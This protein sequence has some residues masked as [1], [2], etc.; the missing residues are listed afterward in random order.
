MID[1]RPE[2]DRILIAKIWARRQHRARWREL[3]SDEEAAAVT[4]LRG[5]AVGRADLLA[6]VAGVLEGASEGEFGELL[7][8]QAA[9]LRR[10]AGADPDHQYRPGSK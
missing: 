2:A 8:R 7:A 10:K 4:V 9:Q 1:K 3:S 6:E 5:I